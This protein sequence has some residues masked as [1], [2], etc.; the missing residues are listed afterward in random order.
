MKPPPLLS[1]DTGV[2]PWTGCTFCSAVMMA[3]YGGIS[4]PLGVTTA[5]HYAL[6]R[7]AGKVPGHEAALLSDVQKGYAVRYG[8]QAHLFQGS[9]ADLKALGDVYALVQ[10]NYADLPLHYRRWDPSFT[11]IHAAG[12]MPPIAWWQDPLARQREIM[13]GFNGESMAMG[14]LDAYALGYGGSIHALYLRANEFSSGGGPATPVPVMYDFSV[15]PG[16]GGSLVLKGPGHSY[17]KLSDGTQHACGDPAAFGTRRPAYPVKISPPL[18][19]DP[20]NPGDRATG[21][22]IGTD[23]AFLL[24]SDVVFTPDSTVDCTAAT[25]PLEA[26]IKNAQEALA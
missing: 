3:S 24:A 11:G 6:V 21:Y 12:Y 23:A 2:P 18:P 16:P 7:A 14:V 25:A 19:P 4:L 10:G 22:L 26:K 8:V 5:E 15:L 17:L 1:E 20:K 13:A 9:I